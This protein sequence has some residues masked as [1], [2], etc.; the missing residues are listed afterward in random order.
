MTIVRIDADLPPLGEC[1]E[2]VSDTGMSLWL[3][4]VQRRLSDSYA[5]R[6]SSDDVT[7]PS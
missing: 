1:L 2:T 7:S 4:K 3:L 5:I 6:F